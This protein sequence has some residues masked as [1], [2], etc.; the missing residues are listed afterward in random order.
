MSKLYTFGYLS[1]KSERIL[2]E[3]IAVSTPIVDVRYSPKSRHYQFTKEGMMKRD[4]IKYYHIGKLGNVNY[5]NA[6]DGNYTEPRIKID[7]IE[8]GLMLLHLIVV[9]YGRA[10]IF[11]ACTSKT[12]CHR[13][14][15]AQ[16]YKEKYNVE[17][18]HL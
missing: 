7:D 5:R 12:L 18:V 8:K 16:A 3:L 10:A 6:L 13:T 9:H 15:V 4:N 14:T 11:C 1:S 17:I 2:S